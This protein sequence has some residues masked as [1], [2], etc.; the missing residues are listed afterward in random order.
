[1]VGQVVDGTPG[2]LYVVAAGLQF[3]V[4]VV[5]APG[6]IKLGDA[7]KVHTGLGAVTV[8]VVPLV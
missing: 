4:S 3:A 1:M 5:P 8:T 6:E 7:V 2:Q